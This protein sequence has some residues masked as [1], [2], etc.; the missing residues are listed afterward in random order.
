MSD[1]RVNASFTE[2]AVSHQLRSADQRDGLLATVRQVPAL[3]LVVLLLVFWAVAALAV[4]RFG[5]VDNLL[6]I[7]RQSSDLI[8]VAIGVMFVL[9][10][11]GID[12]SVGSIYGLGSVVLVTVLLDTGQVL[13]ALAAALVVG[14]AVGLVNGLLIEVVRIPAFITTFGT[15]YIALAVAQMI[16]AGSSL[17]VP[18]DSGLQTFSRGSVA[19]VPN[20][21]LVA[22]VIAVAA[23]VLL[24][25]T[26]FGRAL[27]AVGFNREAARLSGIR[28]GRVMIGA[29]ALSGMLA[30]VGAALLTSRTATGVPTLGGLTG[31]FEVITAAV[32]GGTSL[33]GGRG[34]ILGVVVGALLIRTI[35]T[36]ITL[37]NVTPLLYQAV[38][39]SLILVALV[40]EALRTRFLVKAS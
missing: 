20:L 11:G 36:C 35:G 38:M 32:V 4:P 22:V 14:L 5:S 24:N 7:M 31:T 16:S 12:L 34:T 40:V 10:V 19:G 33:F 6:N 28:V 27:V 29:F 17:S 39:G 25:R 15:F 21:V 23:W 18:G 2:P 8:I 1:V 3:G 9:I 13:L 37:L 26:T 30:G